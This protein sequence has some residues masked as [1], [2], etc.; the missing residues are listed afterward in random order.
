MCISTVSV[1][2]CVQD[3]FNNKV[4]NTV[5]YKVKNITNVREMDPIAKQNRNEEILKF[6]NQFGILM[7]LQV[8]SNMF[9]SLSHISC[10]K[11]SHH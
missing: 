10:R 9:T 3:K 11:E 5:L 7:N 6:N 2:S 8:L 1:L 4:P